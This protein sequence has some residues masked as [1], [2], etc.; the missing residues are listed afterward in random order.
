MYLKNIFKF[1]Q[2]L[3]K[4]FGDAR[5][6]RYKRLSEK[7]DIFKIL[8]RLSLKSELN[9]KS[10]GPVRQRIFSY[11]INGTSYKEIL[12]VFREIFMNNQYRFDSANPSPRIIDC[13]ANIGLSVIYFKMK[14]PDCH[15]LAFEA[16]PEIY[17][18]LNKNIEENKLSGIEAYNLAVSDSEGSVSLYFDPENSLISSLQPNRG[19]PES[20]SVRSVR[21]SDYLSNR[22]FDLVKLDIEGKE[23]NVIQDLRD[24]KTINNASHYLIEY[25]HNIRG[26]SSA[27][28]DFLEIFETS[29]F[30]YN[31][32]TTFEELGSYQDILIFC[33]KASTDK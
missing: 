18:F 3:K 15:I 1:L 14:F 25:H 26:T 11:I 12:Y 17:N 27:L 5:W 24:S 32:I 16:N 29:N 4:S 10:V 30:Q 9:K 2:I 31:L 23:F 6:S 33:F 21:L 19:C 8:F 22:E 28:S 13:G 20:K 7:F